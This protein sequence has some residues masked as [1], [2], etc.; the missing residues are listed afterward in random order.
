M[1]SCCGHPVVNCNVRLDPSI[2]SHIEVEDIAI[3]R[4]MRAVLGFAK[5]YAVGSVMYIEGELLHYETRHFKTFCRT[6]YK[7]Y[8]FALSKIETVDMLE[9]E[10]LPVGLCCRNIQLSPGLR[11][12]VKPNITVFV[13]MP[14]ATNDAVKFSQVL[15]E[16]SSTTARAVWF[17]RYVESYKLMLPKTR[18]K[19]AAPAAHENTARN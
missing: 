3:T 11:I 16:A 14:V 17:G 1:G 2:T 10:T 15:A 6:F 7:H 4:G 5:S 8:V 19:K 13:A 12:S 18:R 9:N